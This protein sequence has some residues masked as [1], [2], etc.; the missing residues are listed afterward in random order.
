MARYMHKN[1]EKFNDGEVNNAYSVAPPNKTEQKS[2][3]Q[4]LLLRNKEQIQ[5]TMM[6]S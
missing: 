2:V 4:T 6:T 1:Q 3:I 5:I